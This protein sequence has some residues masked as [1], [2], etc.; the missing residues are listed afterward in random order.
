[1][2]PILDDILPQL[3]GARV[4]TVIDVKDGYW[5]LKLSEEAS[6]LTATSTP[7]GNIRFLRLPFGPKPSGD[8]FQYFY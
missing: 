5:N 8:K 7:F 1:M 4:F 2:T 6:N 3:E